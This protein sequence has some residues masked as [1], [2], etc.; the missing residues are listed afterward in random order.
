MK[1]RGLLSVLVPATVLVAGVL[2]AMALSGCGEKGFKAYGAMPFGA[3]RFLATALTEEAANLTSEPANGTVLVADRLYCLDAEAKILWSVS[4]DGGVPGSIAACPSLYRAVVGVTMLPA[5]AGSETFRVLLV[6]QDSNGSSAKVT[7]IREF[8]VPQDEAPQLALAR[9]GQ[10]LALVR[11][12]QAAPTTGAGSAP[13]VEIMDMS[14]K[15]IRQLSVLT[16]EQLA[17]W[18]TDE[19]LS[20]VA[21]SLVISKDAGQSFETTFSRASSTENLT[22]ALEQDASLSPDGRLVAVAS[23]EKPQADGASGQQTLTLYSWDSGLKQLWARSIAGQGAQFN[24][25]G[26][27]LLSSWSMTT[28]SGSP[29]PSAPGQTTSTVEVLSASDGKTLWKTET[30]SAGAGLL[31]RWLDQRTLLVVGRGGPG[32]GAPYDLTLVDLSGAQPVAKK[33]STSLMPAVI[34]FDGHS[35]LGFGSRNNLVPVTIR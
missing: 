33:S 19:S 17:S 4:F 24:G 25:D 3:D 9:D 23:R 20:S 32:E 12:G 28:G 8:S 29:A 7:V 15:T 22:S 2:L 18:S 26:T 34:S 6:D 21:L 11:T 30:Q 35:A 31:P 14:G 10:S 1:R 27:M 16:G 13:S 5:Q